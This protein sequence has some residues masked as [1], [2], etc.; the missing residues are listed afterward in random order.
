M[1][2]TDKITEIVKMEFNAD[3]ISISKINEGYSHFMFDVKISKAPFEIVIRFMNWGSEEYGLE[4]ESYVIRLLRKNNIPVPRVYASKKEYLVIEKFNDPN[5]AKIWPILSEKEKI[6]IAVEIGKLLKKMH[7][8]KFGEF[9]YVLDK[10]KIKGPVG[11]F[12][13]KKSGEKT[14]YSPFLRTLF[15]DLGDELAKFLSFKGTSAQ[16][17]AKL[18]NYII[19]NKNKIDYLRKPSLI[20][21]DF[22]R[23]HIF[24]KKKKTKYEITGLID[25]EH[26]AAY[27]PMYDLIKLHREGFFDNPIIKK[28][29]IKGYG[30]IDY[31]AIEVYRIL[32][33][34]QFGVILMDSGDRVKAKK[35]LTEIENKI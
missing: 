18:F 19:M 30:P 26:A 24:V 20:H 12:E 9:G 5:L 4:K 7:K 11:G 6:G 3:V 1:D 29:F 25:F 2:K 16:F 17:L 31:K 13:F 34:F 35:V 28:A 10:G 14:M 22:Q 15:R 21:G 32:R 8:I 23:S 27:P 33:D